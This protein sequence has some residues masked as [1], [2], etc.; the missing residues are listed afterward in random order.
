MQPRDGQ[1]AA[2]LD[3]ACDAGLSSEPFA[4]SVII[5]ASGSSWR[6]L[7]GAG[8]ARSSAAS[9]RILLVTTLVMAGLDPAIFIVGHIQCQNR[10]KITGSCAFGAAP[11]KTI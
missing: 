9:M 2:G 1:G 8:I 10:S 11:V 4:L 5:A 6:F 3:L 7:I